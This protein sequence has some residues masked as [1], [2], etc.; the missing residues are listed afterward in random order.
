[1]GC[2]TNRRRSSDCD[3]RICLEGVALNFG[4][5][6]HGWA[7]KKISLSTLVLLI[8]A[9]VGSIRTLPTTAIFGGS[10]VFFFFLAALLFLLPISLI[11]AEFS[12]RYPEEGGVFNWVKNAFG[13]K[14]GAL[15]VWLQWINTMV[16]YP[17]MLL[18]VA[19]TAAY[20]FDP[21]LA[22]N[23]SF[24]VAT[25]L[26][27]FWT[28]TLLNL[29]S[30]QVSAR[31]NSVCGILGSFFPMGLLIFLA[32]KWLFSGAPTAISLSPQ[33]WFPAFDFS[34]QSGALV[35]IMASLVGMELAGVH[36]TDIENPRKNF[37]KAIGYA[38]ALLISVLLVGALSIALVIPSNEIQF[39]DGVMQTFST[40]LNTFGLGSLI[41]I[42]A[43][44]ITIGSL[45]GS[46][47][48]LIS[49]AKGLLHAAQH[50][51]LPSYFLHTNN[52]GVSVRILVA[53]AILI[54]FFCLAIQLMPSVNGF[55][56]LLMALSTGLYMLMYILLFAAALK[57]GRPTDSSYAIPRGVRTLSCFAGIFGCALTLLIGFQPPANVDVGSPIRYFCTISIGLALM[58]A[59]VFFL[60]TYQKSKRQVLN[61][62]T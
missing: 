42:L 10:L 11:S 2:R 39:V 14:A 31:L 44:L 34:A 58:I 43:L 56:W 61:S 16:W 50:Q 32:V 33:E 19:G 3:S 12:S 49:P 62:T 5:L 35:T 9:S 4:V 45:G 17:T 22:T 15:A 54:S 40:F 55:Y 6:H 46:I 60:W 59:P 53:Q 37:P 26:T 27:V 13:E 57:L 41:P 7:M 36:V 28:L 25:T 51:F 23:K 47:N 24:L 30:V 38:V 20:L 21:A 48:W 29:K 52:Q 18:F 8:V 1:M